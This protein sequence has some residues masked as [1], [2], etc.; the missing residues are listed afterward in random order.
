MW[1][2]GKFTPS[3]LRGRIAI[4]VAPGAFSQK[5]RE[6]VWMEVPGQPEG[7]VAFGGHWHPKSSSVGV[8]PWPQARGGTSTLQSKGA[9][10]ALTGS[11]PPSQGAQ[12]IPGAPCPHTVHSH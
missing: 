11:I 2:I 5:D 7:G 3:L 4:P 10:P 9:P 1:Y 12:G 6:G 8:S